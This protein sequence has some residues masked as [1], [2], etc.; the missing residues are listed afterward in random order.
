MN[1]EFQKSTLNAPLVSYQLPHHY[2]ELMLDYFQSLPAKGKRA[3]AFSI[4]PSFSD[5]LHVVVFEENGK[6]NA[7]AYSW[8][9]GHD[10]ERAANEI[11]FPPT[12]LEKKSVVAEDELNDFETFFE[13]LCT[14]PEEQLLEKRGVLILDGVRYKLILFREGKPVRSFSWDSASEAQGAM[15]LVMRLGDKPTTES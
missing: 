11:N 4:L 10:F 8:K 7:H 3:L 12:I 9:M 14:E 6:L 13:A 5:M 15:K 1:N 2:V